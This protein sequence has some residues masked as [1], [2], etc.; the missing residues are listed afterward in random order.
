MH[1]DEKARV[2]WGNAAL[3]FGT[4]VDSG[5]QGQRQIGFVTVGSKTFWR[6]LFLSFSRGKPDVRK[7]SER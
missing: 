1:T 3:F 6:E 4:Q 7:I 2:Q 5:G